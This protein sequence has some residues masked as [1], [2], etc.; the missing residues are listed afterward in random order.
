[1]S[2]SQIL[3]DTGNETDNEFYQLCTENDSKWYLQFVAL[4]VSNPKVVQNNDNTRTWS[5]E[6]MRDEINMMTLEYTSKNITEELRLNHLGCI[7]GSILYSN[8]AYYRDSDRKLVVTYDSELIMLAMS[9]T[10]I[11]MDRFL[12]VVFLLTVY[13][14]LF[15]Y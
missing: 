11:Q 13:S 5:F 8:N 3:S 4:I 15:N 12:K 1:M 14:A 2:Q 7:E 6:L 10:Q 9:P